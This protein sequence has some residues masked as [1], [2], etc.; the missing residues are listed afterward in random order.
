MEEIK[1][2]IKKTTVESY[3]VRCDSFY[4]ADIT[5]D[6]DGKMGR[7]QIVSDFGS[8]Q[9]YWG[10]CGCSFKE[11]LQKINID[12]AA[13]KFGAHKWFDLDRTIISL[14][15]RINDYTD[16]KEDLLKELESLESSSGKD[17][18]IHIM[19]NCDEIMKMENYYPDMI[20]SIEPGFKRFWK[21]V[22]PV[23][24]NQ[25]SKELEQ[26]IKQ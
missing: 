24:T 25:L 1:Y 8:W 19:H 3:K 12:Y 4:W 21:E 23:F 20:Y 15:E 10:A 26:S 11:F 18:F 7:I 14:K 22:W 6:A 5:I 2:S 13:D 17:E 9:N 16:D